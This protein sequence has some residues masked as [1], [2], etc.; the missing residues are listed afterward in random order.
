M[1]LAH[2]RFEE[3]AEELGKALALNFTKDDTGIF[4]EF[5][6]YLA[7][8][9]DVSYAIVAVDSKNQFPLVYQIKI[10]SGENE[11]NLAKFR[12]KIDIPGVEI[13]RE[14]YI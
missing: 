14:I 10:N 6:S 4:G 11:Y 3:I 12:E 8:A 9:E 2:Y 13:H 5:D 7:D 1:I